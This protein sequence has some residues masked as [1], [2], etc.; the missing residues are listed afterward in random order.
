MPTN[1]SPTARWCRC[2]AMAVLALALCACKQ[3]LYSKLT[4]ADA[5]EMLS[6]LLQAKLDATKVSPDGKTWT[7]SVESNDLG[8][9]LIELRTNGLPKA[10]HADLGEMFKKDGLISTPTEER[11][12]FIYGMSQELEKT[13]GSIDGV[14]NARVHIVLPNNDPLAEHVKP[15]SASVFIKHRA[16]TNVTTLTP[17][18]KN[19]V[20]RSIEGLNYENVNVTMMVGEAQAQAP[21]IPAASFATSKY[22]MLIAGVGLLI[23]LGAIVALMIP[24][25]RSKWLPA[26]LRTAT[27]AASGRAP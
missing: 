18:V 24:R 23:A 22:V 25:L 6:V 5:N 9:A 1:H 13:L 21:I 14:I 12:R 11:V 16:A 19:L 27:A 4:E 20:I 3:D 15:S 17:A 10:H 2:L 7:I 8:S 26:R